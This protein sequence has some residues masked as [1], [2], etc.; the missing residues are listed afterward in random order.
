MNF[1]GTYFYDK[2]GKIPPNPLKS[3]DW[4]E[5]FSVDEIFRMFI[6]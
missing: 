5:F 6:F 2:S 1:S 4:E 3:M